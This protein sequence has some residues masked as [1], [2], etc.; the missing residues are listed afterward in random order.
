MQWLNQIVDELIA[1]HPDGEILIETGSSPSGTYHFG[2]MR[3]LLTA[4]A[5]LLELRRRGRVARHVQFVD[6]LDALRKIPVNVPADFEQYLGKPICDIPAPDDSERSYAD[7]FLQGLMDACQLLGVEVQYERAHLKYRDGWYAPAIERALERVSQARQALETISGRQL[8]E[9]WTPIQVMENGRLKNRKFLSIDTTAKT[10]MYEDAEGQ[11]QTAQYDKGEVKLDWRLDWP[12]RW[13]LQKVACEPS[14]RDHMTK[15]SS[16]DTGAQIVRDV[17]EAEPPY[18]VAYDFVNMVGDTKK[19]SASKGTGLDAVEGAS[20]IPPEV[21]RYFILRAPASKRLYFDPVNSVM[22]TMDEY[23][24]L[25]AKTDKTESEEQ[26][27]YIC[28]RGIEKQT[29]SR[30]PFSL[31]VASYQAAL[32]DPQHTL[33]IISRTA[34]A[35]VAEADAE[36]I[37][38][39][40]Q[41]INTWLEKRAPEDVKFSIEQAPNY[42]DELS[43]AQKQFLGQLADK[44]AAAPADADGEWFHLAIYELKDSS[45]LSPK[46][47]FATLYR[48]L[49]NKEH[50]PRAGWFLSILPR[51]KLL[52]RLRLDTSEP[53]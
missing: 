10:L 13:W 22:Q 15:G 47:L 2:H 41:F 43:G 33:D 38:A 52:Q 53:W 50:G 44:I 23:A 11:P 21:M 28:N 46:E 3:E 16:Y 37:K 30:V 24:A 9:H 49:I 17:F 42:L 29:V 18:A 25:S 34:Y 20:I 5:I 31:L 35:E 51:D 1:R 40:L 19:M 45:G 4:D 12:A 27:L 7:Q 32:K 26:L 6:D 39:E 14:G 48:V 36:I 8:D